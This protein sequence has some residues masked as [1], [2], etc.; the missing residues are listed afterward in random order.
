M[1]NCYVFFSNFHDKNL[2]ILVLIQQAFFYFELA[3][4]SALK[5]TLKC[6]NTETFFH[7]GNFC[8]I[9]KNH[10]KWSGLAF[11]IYLK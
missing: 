4:I 2:G 9:K 10:S 5:R 7:S 8:Y 3:S 6:R 1:N 11:H